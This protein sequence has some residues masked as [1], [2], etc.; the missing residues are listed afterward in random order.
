M[1]ANDMNTPDKVINI[2]L[3]QVG[4]LEKSKAAY[5]SDPSVLYKFTEGAGSDNYTKYGKEMHDIYPAVMDFPA[6]WCDSFCDWCF[7]QA[8][9]VANAKA[10]LG[11]NFDD[12]TPNSANLYKKKGAYYKA[13]PKYGDQ[14]F[15]NNGTRI[16][17]T[18][19]VYKVDANNVYTIEGNTSGG[20]TVIAN[21]GSVA[22]KSYPLSYERIDG[23]GR[24]KYDEEIKNGWVQDG[25]K[26]YYYQNGTKLIKEW[27][28]YK[29]KWYRVGNDGAMLTDWHQIYD[30][31]GVLGWYYFDK[32]GA[33]WHET[34]KRDGSLEVWEIKE[35]N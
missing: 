6:Y 19:L 7:F 25:D 28:K 18:G 4:Y 1:R 33:L 20:N 14:I 32:D 23:Y 16:C 30:K 35:D 10:L 31:D 11:G 21:G 15:F 29:N 27:I 24:P 3:S 8:Y 5:L 22:K 2:A 34:D 17:H 9:G 12:Y 26:W 13:N